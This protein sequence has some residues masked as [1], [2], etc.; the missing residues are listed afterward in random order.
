[1]RYL[2]RL[3]AEKGSAGKANVPGYYVGGKTGT[4]EKV[5]GGRYSK[6]K[7]LNS[8]TAVLPADNPR[9]LILIMLDEPKALPETHGYATSGW[10]AVPVGGAVI[11]RVAPL[12]GLPP[13]FDLP[14][15][16]QLILANL[17]ASR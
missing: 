16:D 11:A 7:L 5:V 17:T 4:S 3:N 6:T 9:Y 14:K 13:R 10:N 8:F 12:L 1:M 15:A 2:L